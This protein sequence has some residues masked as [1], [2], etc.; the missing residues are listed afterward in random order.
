VV[1]K[2]EKKE[3]RRGTLDLKLVV[4]FSFLFVCLCTLFDV[5]QEYL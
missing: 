3:K 4:A 2:E 1:L 5:Y